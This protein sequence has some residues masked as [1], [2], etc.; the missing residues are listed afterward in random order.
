MREGLIIQKLDF[1]GV[2]QLITMCEAGIIG[3]VGIN[4]AGIGLCANAL[5]ADRNLDKGA[6][7]HFFFRKALQADTLAEAIGAI[8]TASRAGAINALLARDDEALALETS[9]VDIQI[10]HPDEGV[11][12]H[13][14]NFRFSNPRFRDAQFFMN[15]F[16]STFIRWRR[17]EKIL[18]ANVG[19]ISERTFMKAFSDH[20]DHPMSVCWHLNAKFSSAPQQIGVA[21]WIMDRDASA[22]WFTDDHP[23]GKLCSAGGG[24]LYAYLHNLIA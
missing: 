12:A 21:S 23:W 10:V 15:K 8:G 18:R 7:F 6:P 5:T 20:F 1:K 14:N 17:V 13:S 9:P 19:N 4:Q 2:P 16:P 22:T 3:K 24:R 11:L